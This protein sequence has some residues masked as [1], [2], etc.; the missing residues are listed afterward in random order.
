M[1]TLHQ[2]SQF[3]LPEPTTVLGFFVFPR[4]SQCINNVYVFVLI[5]LYMCFCFLNTENNYIYTILVPCLFLNFMIYLG[6]LSISRCMTCLI[7]L[8]AAEYFIA[9]LYH[10]LLSNL[11]WMGIHVISKLLLLQIVVQWI[12]WY[13]RFASTCKCVCKINVRRGIAGSEYLNL[14]FDSYC[15]FSPREFLICNFNIISKVKYF[16]IN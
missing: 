4:Y 9:W 1:S 10:N 15:H 12:S 7:V 2:V 6:N 14:K 13:L 16:L 8:T 11:L 5:Y 3:P